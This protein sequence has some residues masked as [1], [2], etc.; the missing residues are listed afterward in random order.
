MSRPFPVDIESGRSEGRRAERADIDAGKSI[1]RSFDVALE[2]LRMRHEVVRKSRRLCMLQMRK[3]GHQSTG[4]LHG[5]TEAPCRH[6]L[7]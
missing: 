2:S 1:D 4:V 5:R 7:D 3:P 6:L